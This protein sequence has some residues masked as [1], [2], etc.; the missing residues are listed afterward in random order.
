MK[1]SGCAQLWG[2]AAAERRDKPRH[3]GASSSQCDAAMTKTEKKSAVSSSVVA[4][5]GS[6]S[7]AEQVNNGAV[8]LSC[9]EQSKPKVMK[10]TSRESLHQRNTE[11][12]VYDDGTN[13]FFW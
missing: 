12:E 10:Q 1:N 4:G 13:T 2:G 3:R 6:V 7:A 8:E 5:K 9:Q 11:C